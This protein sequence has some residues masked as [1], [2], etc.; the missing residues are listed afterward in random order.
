MGKELQLRQENFG[1]CSTDRVFLREG[2]RH[3]DAKDII[4]ATCSEQDDKTKVWHVKMP[5]FIELETEVPSLKAPLLHVLQE[6]ESD[7]I[8]YLDDPTDPVLCPRARS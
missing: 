6:D 5:E 2:L 4:G 1:S 8:E 7:L 3:E